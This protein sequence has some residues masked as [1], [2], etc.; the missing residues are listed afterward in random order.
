MGYTLIERMEAKE[1][2]VKRG[3]GDVRAIQSDAEELHPL[4]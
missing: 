3:L 2:G 1:V 4:L